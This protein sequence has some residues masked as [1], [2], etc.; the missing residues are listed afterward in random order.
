[1]LSVDLEKE[2][3]ATFTVKLSAPRVVKS[4]S[5]Q[6]CV[7]YSKTPKWRWRDAALVGPDWP[8]ALLLVLVLLP[9]YSTVCSF[10]RCGNFCLQVLIFLK[11]LWDL[12]LDRCL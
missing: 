8:G 6:A 9:V 2:R 12:A 4:T 10:I 7:L 1:M 5:N 3:N 11:I